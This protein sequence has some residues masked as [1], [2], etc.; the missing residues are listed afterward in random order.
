M[1]VNSGTPY[2]CFIIL[3][4]SHFYEENEIIYKICR[5]KTINIS[6]LTIYN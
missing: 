5:K 2:I 1:S 6:I 4:Q 3:K